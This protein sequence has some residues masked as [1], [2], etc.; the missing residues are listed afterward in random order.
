MFPNARPVFFAVRL[1]PR[2]S[3]TSV[4]SLSGSPPRPPLSAAFRPS[5]SHATFL[6]VRSSP[7]PAFVFL[8]THRPRRP[9]S[10]PPSRRQHGHGRP[11]LTWLSRLL[12]RRNPNDAL[13]LSQPPGWPASPE[14]PSKSA[15]VGGEERE[16]VGEGDAR[17]LTLA[18]SPSLTPAVRVEWACVARSRRRSHIRLCVL[19][20]N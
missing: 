15:G 1:L 16:N 5:S 10:P 2:S 11:A 8:L 6:L 3:S 14:P 9:P 18:R 19:V 7:D 17:T 13:L 20:R 4:S 12:R